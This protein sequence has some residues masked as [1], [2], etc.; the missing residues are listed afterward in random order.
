MRMMQPLGEILSIFM[1]PKATSKLT[2][3]TTLAGTLILQF[4]RWRKRKAGSQAVK[5]LPF[6]GPE[7][8]LLLN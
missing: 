7:L 4:P 3:I 2:R 8:A 1:T 6:K 5:E